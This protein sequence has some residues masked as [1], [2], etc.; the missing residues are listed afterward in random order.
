MRKFSTSGQLINSDLRQ[1]S[2]ALRRYLKSSSLPI[3]ERRSN[4]PEPSKYRRDKVLTSIMRRELAS[5]I[6]RWKTV[7]A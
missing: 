1:N 2:N 7:A 3:A 6:N 5:I 4:R